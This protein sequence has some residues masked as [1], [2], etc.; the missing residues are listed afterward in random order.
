MFDRNGG[1]HRCSDSFN[2]FD[3]ERAAVQLRERAC[4]RQPE[5]CALLGGADVAAQCHKGISKPTKLIG[6]N[7]DARV[8]DREGE[9]AALFA[10]ADG[11]ASAGRR[12]LDGIRKKISEAS[13]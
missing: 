3:L 12:E 2:A 1:G 8:R 5:T 13:A 6:R 10:H 4:E 7:T 9:Q 11:H